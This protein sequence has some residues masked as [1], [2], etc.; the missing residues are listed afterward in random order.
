[1][2]QAPQLP[3]DVDLV[4]LSAA[5]Y[6]DGGQWDYFDAGEDSDEICVAIKKLDGYDVIV[7]RGSIALHDWYEDLKAVPISTKMGTVHTGFYAD[8]DQAWAELKPHITQPT[9]VTGHSLGAARADILCG[10]M[11][12]DGQPPVR[13]VVFGEPKPGLPDFA[14]FIAKIPSD[15]YRNGNARNHDLVTDVPL[16]LLPPFNFIHPKK[17]V[18]VDEEPTGSM[19]ERMGLFSYHHIELYV[20]AVTAYHKEVVS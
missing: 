4:N 16:K 7:F 17:L 19:F 9:L 15:S 14:N 13:R 12:L 18:L 8:M 2:P 1:M 11:L 5:I 10:L 6:Q 3:T 20:A